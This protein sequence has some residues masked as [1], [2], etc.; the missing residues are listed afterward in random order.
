VSGLFVMW[1]VF[2]QL[3]GSSAAT[4]MKKEFIFT[5]RRL[6]QLVRE[7]LATDTRVAVDRIGALR[8]TI[9]SGF[10]RARAFADG[11]LFEF[12][13]TRDADLAWRRRLLAWQPRFRLVFLT[14]VA[15]LKYRLGLPGFQLPS[16]LAAAQADFDRELAKRIDG[17]ADRLEGKR[18]Q[19]D[20]ALER[21]LVRLEAVS[22]T[23]TSDTR[24]ESPG[25]VHTFLPLSRRIERLTALLD[26][27]VARGL[28][29]VR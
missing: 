13:P 4:A 19:S 21:S 14:R 26:E 12:G 29:A 6:A 22:R 10:D 1:I 15:L 23:Q 9:D 27:D 24:P 11:V 25:S 28:E 7:P 2:D 20:D 5:V 3:W 18:S 8:E 16:S 17:I